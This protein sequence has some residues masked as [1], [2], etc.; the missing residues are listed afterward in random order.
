MRGLARPG[1]WEAERLP[2][3]SVFPLL[4]DFIGIFLSERKEGYM[5]IT[6]PLGE[7]PSSLGWSGDQWEIS[8]W[9]PQLDLFNKHV[10]FYF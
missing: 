4:F 7:Q 9:P 1:G 3:L 8:L 6:V 2:F 5:R 10:N